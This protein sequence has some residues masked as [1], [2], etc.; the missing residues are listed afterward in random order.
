MAQ[1][2]DLW[3]LHEIAIASAE[4]KLAPAFAACTVRVRPAL[5]GVTS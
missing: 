4:P 1:R 3:T 2:I 5:G